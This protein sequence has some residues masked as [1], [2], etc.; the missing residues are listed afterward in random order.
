[1][2]K[3]VYATKNLKSGNFNKPDLQDFPP[4]NAREV[5]EVS[6]KEAPV[7][8]KGFIKELEI[9]YLGEFDTKTGKFDQEKMTFIV[10][11]SE[12]VGD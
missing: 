4:E 7:E 12:I 1:M 9:Y 3:Y 5:Y 11:G 10:G 6:F 8:Q 2:T